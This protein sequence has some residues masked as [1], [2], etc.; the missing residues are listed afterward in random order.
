MKMMSEESI[1]AHLLE[2]FPKA[3]LS[4]DNDG[5]LIVNTNCQSVIGT[6]GKFYIDMDGFK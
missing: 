1:L 4:E 3:T 2:M 6:I 5:Q